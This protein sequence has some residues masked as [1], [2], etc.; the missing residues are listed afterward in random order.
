MLVGIEG[1]E[2]VVEDGIEPGASMSMLCDL[3]GG[4]VVGETQRRRE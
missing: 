1:T 2:V 4:E 3:W